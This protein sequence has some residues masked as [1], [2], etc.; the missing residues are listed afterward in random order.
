L[1]ES[2]CEI[3]PEDSLAGVYSR[4]TEA[5]RSKLPRIFDPSEE[6]TL[7]FLIAYPRQAAGNAL[8]GGFSKNRDP[9]RI[10][11]VHARIELWR[12]HSKKRFIR[13]KRTFLSFTTAQQ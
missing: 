7:S 4:D 5:L 13:F 6:Q 11:C 3:Q 1:P 10:G 2:S 9:E 12:F 8:V